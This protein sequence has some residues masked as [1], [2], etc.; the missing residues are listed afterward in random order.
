[1]KEGPLVAMARG[2]DASAYRFQ[3]V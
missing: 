1:M 3:P 2:K